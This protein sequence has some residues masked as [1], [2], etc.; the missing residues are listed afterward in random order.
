MGL[1]GAVALARSTF[2]PRR[3]LRPGLEWARTHGLHLASLPAPCT[4]WH[5]KEA[6]R[7]LRTEGRER[8]GVASPVWQSCYQVQNPYPLHEAPRTQQKPPA[9]PPLLTPTLTSTLQAK[10]SRFPAALGPLS[11][12]Y[13]LRSCFHL[14]RT[15]SFTL[16]NQSSKTQPSTPCT[17][18]PSL[19]L[20]APEQPLLTP[21]SWEQSPAASWA[22][23]WACPKFRIYLCRGRR[24]F[25]S[26]LL[27]SGRHLFRLVFF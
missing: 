24:S 1:L 8:E 22:F 26:S 21:C 16:A 19:A 11:L 4:A 20:W 10:T 9:L 12:T 3:F 13:R 5:R 23:H 18:T 7:H 2:S 6:P 14:P 27:E 15:L 17:R 25:L